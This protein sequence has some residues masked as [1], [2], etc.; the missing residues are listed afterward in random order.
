[1]E[2]LERFYSIKNFDDDVVPKIGSPEDEHKRP[3]DRGLIAA[4]RSP[5][6]TEEY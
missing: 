5:L 2:K 6:P 4:K 1:M 3:A